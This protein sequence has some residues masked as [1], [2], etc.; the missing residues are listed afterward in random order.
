MGHI[1]T[2]AM[3][4]G[5]VPTPSRQ[6]VIRQCLNA[7]DGMAAINMFLDTQLPFAYVHLITLMVNVQ[8]VIMAMKAGLVFAMAAAQGNTFVMLQQVFS[9]AI[10][11]FLY[12]AILSIAYMVTDP[13]G[14]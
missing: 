11:V 2:D 5:R 3:D 6:A 12:Q 13:F 14:D 7:R 1:V 8:N 4:H 9:T 10:I